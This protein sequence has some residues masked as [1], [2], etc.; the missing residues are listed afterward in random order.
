MGQLTVKDFIDIVSKSFTLNKRTCAVCA[1]L[2]IDKVC[3]ATLDIL[4]E[5]RSFAD[6]QRYYTQFASSLV[7]EGK[8]LGEHRFRH[9]R[10]K[11][12]KSKAVFSDEDLRKLDILQ[13]E[14]EI[15]QRLYNLKYEEAVQPDVQR[16][17]IRRQRYHNLSLFNDQRNNALENIAL[18]EQG[19]LP[20][21]MATTYQP[22]SG[23]CPQC[24]YVRTLPLDYG[25]LIRQEKDNVLKLTKQIDVILS[26]LEKNNFMAEK[27]AKSNT[28]VIQVMNTSLSDMQAKFELML[29]EIKASLDTLLPT[30][31]EIVMQV[32]R[33][34]V[35][36][37]NQG[38][39]PVLE[40]TKEVLQIEAQ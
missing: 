24:G 15:L 36:H 32:M 20:Q 29:D 12:V 28:T 30:Q 16:K 9:H 22:Q 27:A 10:N 2:P 35:N 18:L 11:C 25:S 39:V 3:E 14:A 26:D 33:V 17:E 34:I 40:K 19:I 31:P 23:S 4:F 5:R 38:V 37:M 21:I 13:D 1:N 7:A 8:V 6:M